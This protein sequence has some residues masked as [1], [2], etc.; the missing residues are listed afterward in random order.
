M[1]AL[2]YHNGALGD[3]LTTLPALYRLRSIYTQEITLVG[4]PSYGKLAEYCDLITATCDAESSRFLPLFTKNRKKA[5]HD[6]LK[7]FDTVVLFANEDAPIVQHAQQLPV[8]H[9]YWQKPFPDNGVH[10]CDFH[11]SL[12]PTSEQTGYPLAEK[13]KGG[14]SRKKTTGA[15]TIAIAP[16]SGSYRKN[17]PFDR[18]LDIASLLRRCGFTIFWISGPAERT[19][20][21]PGSDQVLNTPDLV[22]LSSFL[23]RCT[24]FIGNDSGITHLAAASGCPRVV[25]LFGPS[26]PT[27]WR[28]CGPGEISVLYQGSSCAPCHPISE[29]DPCNQDCMKQISV[30]AV[31]AAVL[32]GYK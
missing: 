8:Q 13:N 7:Q 19:F 15:P 32:K 10:V 21:F 28:P 31:T 27:V 11:C 14:L 4:K 2:I 29:H 1:P 24:C 5:A 30:H 16:G 22:A 26:N 9:L 18:F 6:L 3:F 20:S 12:F 25:A 17:W 23:S